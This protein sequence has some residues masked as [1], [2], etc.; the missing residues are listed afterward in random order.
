VLLALRL[1][2]DDRRAAPFVLAAMWM[3]ALARFA[4]TKTVDRR[5]HPPFPLQR[6]GEPRLSVV[7]VPLAIVS[8]I[9]LGAYASASWIGVL[10]E[11]PVWPRD[12]VLLN[13]AVN[14]P[15]LAAIGMLG[16]LGEE[17]GW[18]GYLQPRLDQLGVPGSMLWVIA[19]ETL[20]HLPL[21][22]FAGYLDGAASA[23]SF[24]LFIGQ[25]LGLVPVWTWATYRWRTIWIAAW[26]HTW[27]N[28]VSQVLVPNALGA[29]NPLVLGESGI[30]PAACYLV[31]AAAIFGISRMR[32][33]RWRD[34]AGRALSESPRP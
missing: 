29:G 4:A 11:P 18:R 34:L 30:L 28:A 24:A 21:I 7:L 25:G 1:S 15:L 2:V 19:V 27:H 10:L 32:G 20:F 26:F 3:P 14:L 17:I 31:A 22:L 33:E 16:S 6:W 9:Y 23:V 12:R 5:W 13:V 8:A